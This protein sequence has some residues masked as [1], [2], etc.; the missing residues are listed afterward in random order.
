MSRLCEEVAAHSADAAIYFRLPSGYRPLPRA[1]TFMDVDCRGRYRSLAMTRR[2]VL[3]TFVGGVTIDQFVLAPFTYLR[4]S[5]N[6]SQ[7]SF[8]I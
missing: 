6:A 1:S 7:R 4:P 8:S 5:M 3:S 2:G